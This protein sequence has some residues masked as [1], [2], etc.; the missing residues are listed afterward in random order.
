MAKEKNAK[1]VCSMYIPSDFGK[2]IQEAAVDMTKELGL[3]YGG[4]TTHKP[5]ETDYVGSLTKLKDANC[6]LVAVAL[7]VRGVITAV[8]TAKKIGWNDVSFVGSAASFHTAVAKVPGGVT[9]GFYAGAGW[10]DL[11]ARAAE[12]EVAAW[13][14][15]YTEAT[16]EKF[17]GTGALLGRSAAEIMVR[18]LD[19]AG[20]DLT[21]E[22]FVKAM[23]SLKY[24]DKISGNTVQLGP[25]DHTASEEIFI[26]KIEGGSWKI[27]GQAK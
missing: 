7:S 14:K 26:S 1:T 15:S 13:I 18:A 24:E 9:D 20:K 12:P 22:S 5:D 2:E 3:T 27:V 23:E 25:D 17:P 8:A 21:T 16:G 19:A 11:E 6:D 4:E 10:Q